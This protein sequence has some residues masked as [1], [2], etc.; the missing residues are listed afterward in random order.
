MLVNIG[1]TVAMISERK[2]ML[3]LVIL[4]FFKVVLIIEPR[5]LSRFLSS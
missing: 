5:Y 1:F 3:N 4:V 2:S